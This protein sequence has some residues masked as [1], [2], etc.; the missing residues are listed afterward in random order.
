[1]DKRSRLQDLTRREE[2]L[3]QALGRSRNEQARLLGALALYRRDPPPALLVHPNSAKDAVRAQI[4]ARALAPEIQARS[5]ALALQLQDLRTLRREVD[6]TSESLFKSESAVAEQRAQLEQMIADKTVLQ[7]S[8]V[9]QA[10]TDEA[11]LR[12]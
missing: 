12:E 1:G 5:H 2:A 11:M 6:A 3:N 7:R 4:L 8:L 10:E 9:A